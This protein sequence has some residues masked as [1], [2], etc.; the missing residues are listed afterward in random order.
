M[1]KKL[2]FLFI[3]FILFSCSTTPKNEIT[4]TPPIAHFS[5]DVFEVGSKNAIIVWEEAHQ[6]DK[7]TITYEIIL[8]EKQV[9]DELSGGFTYTLRNLSPETAY[10]GMIKAIDDKGNKS[11]TS[12]AFQTAGENISSDI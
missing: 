5:S 4:S 2:A 9:I 1:C 7:K 3:A 8:N 12:F 11:I 6:L 10:S